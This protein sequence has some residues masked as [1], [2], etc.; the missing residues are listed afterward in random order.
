MNGNNEMILG[1]RQRIF[2]EFA[3]FPVLM[4][5]CY[6][7]HCYKNV[8]SEIRGGGTT[9]GGT[10]YRVRVLGQNEEHRHKIME[11]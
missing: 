7:S 8:G 9:Q 1:I 6:R 4:R 10:I 5:S 11:F 3:C 2:F